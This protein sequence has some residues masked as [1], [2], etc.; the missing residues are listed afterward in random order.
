MRP[1]L[2][3]VLLTLGVLAAC[4]PSQSD[5]SAFTSTPPATSGLVESAGSS[6]GTG[7][8]TG[9][10]GASAGTSTTSAEVSTT[11]I[12]GEGGAT[13]WVLDV[14]A[15]PDGG[16]GKPAGCKGKIDFLFVVSRW[17]GMEGF[18]EQL[19]EAFPQFIDT[20]EAKF[21]DFDYHIMVV[22]GDP[23]W[24]LSVCDDVCPKPCEVP[25]YP[26]GYT[27]NKCDT[28]LGAG[29]VFPAG[30]MSSNHA[31]PI[32]G[33]RRYM[34]K[35][36]TDLKD[37]FA[38]VARVGVS[39]WAAIGET[40]STTVRP[41]MNDPG[42]CNAGFLREDALLMVTLITNTYDQD[43]VGPGSQN[44]SPDTWAASVRE[45]KHGS[46]ASVVVLGIIPTFG[47]LCEKE[48]RICQ[49]LELFPY[50]LKADLW[51]GNYAEQF[52]QAADL[53]EEA[54]ASFVPPG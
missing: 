13:T 23:M 41:W 15:V 11:S 26:C 5:S 10:E 18:Q 51:A 2:R 8:T 31:C 54:C 28:T 7:S 45:A 17:G 34:L 36:Q 37:T 53:V 40:L 49:M 22:D 21:S 6:T 24:G 12:S 9:S 3:P 47:A 33:G 4:Q 27:P 32:D 35:G 48:D 44:G 46:L 52:K 19:L 43:G 50:V 25:G 20:I 39:G 42:S 1:R 38:C 29:V 14:G 30:G 16:D